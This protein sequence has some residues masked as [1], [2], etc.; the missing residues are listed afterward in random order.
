MATDDAMP[1]FFVGWEPSGAIKRRE[2]WL[3]ECYSPGHAQRAFYVAAV[4]RWLPASFHRNAIILFILMLYRSRSWRRYHGI[5]LYYTEHWAVLY[6]ASSRNN[7]QAIMYIPH[8]T[9]LSTCYFIADSLICL[10]IEICLVAVVASS[11]NSASDMHD[12]LVAWRAVAH[13]P[14]LVGVT[15]PPSSPSLVPAHNSCIIAHVWNAS[16]KQVRRRSRGYVLVR[17]SCCRENPS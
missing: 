2:S 14:R 6:I 13:W 9:A 4:W 11:S 15:N 10:F 17:E 7:R 3:T 5:T 16:H 8:R 12:S 1:I